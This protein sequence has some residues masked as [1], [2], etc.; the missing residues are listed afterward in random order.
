Y[1]YDDDG[2]LAWS[3]TVESA[4][5]TEDDRASALEWQAEQRLICSCGHP[6]DETTDD[7]HRAARIAETVTCWACAAKE[8]LARNGGLDEP[9]MKLSARKR[10]PSEGV[11]FG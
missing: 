1:H 5:W 6:L 2:R 7:E 4:E 3:E 11:T 8:R 10:P 9:G